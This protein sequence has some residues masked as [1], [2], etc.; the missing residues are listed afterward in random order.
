M[1]E[2]ETEIDNKIK[3]KRKDNKVD[4]HIIRI[5]KPAVKVKSEENSEEVKE[6]EIPEPGK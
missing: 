3:D 4:S 5:Q 1:E 6:P 2:E